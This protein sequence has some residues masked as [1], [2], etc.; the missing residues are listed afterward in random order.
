MIGL[1]MTIP[2]LTAHMSQGRVAIG[3]VG[4]SVVARAFE[5]NGYTVTTSYVNGDLTVINKSGE[6][7]YVEVKTSRKASNGRWMFTLFKRGSQNHKYADF[8]VLL[9]VMKSGFSIPFV[10]PIEHCKGV[11]A[12]TIPS[13]PGHYQGKY[14][15]FRQSLRRL[16]LPQ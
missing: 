10:I 4:E 6:M 7:F 12:I 14:A 1:Q 3:T 5:D 13:Y 2:Q 15:T 9:C 8:V 16:R 11:N